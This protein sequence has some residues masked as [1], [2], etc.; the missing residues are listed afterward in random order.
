M[1]NTNTNL[2]VGDLASAL[3]GAGLVMITTDL[4]TGLIL[5]GVAVALKIL[6]AVMTKN[7]YEISSHAPLG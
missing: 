1:N 6:V 5:V 7:G 4:V 3:G 2:S